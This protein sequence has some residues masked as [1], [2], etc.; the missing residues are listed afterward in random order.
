MRS[1]HLHWQRVYI[2]VHPDKCATASEGEKKVKEEKFKELYDHYEK[3]ITLL[4]DVYSMKK[5]LDAQFKEE[6]GREQALEKLKK[7]CDRFKDH[8]FDEKKSYPDCIEMAL[9]ILNINLD[10]IKK[11]DSKYIDLI[12][13]KIKEDIGSINLNLI[14]NEDA[15]LIELKN[16]EVKIRRSVTFLLRLFSNEEAQIKLLSSASG[17]AQDA[18]KIMIDTRIPQK[19]KDID[20][21]TDAKKYIQKKLDLLK[22]NSAEYLYIDYKDEMFGKYKTMLTLFP[23]LAPIGNPSFF[24]LEGQKAEAKAKA[25]AEAEAGSEYF[26]GEDLIKKLDTLIQKLSEDIKVLTKAK[27]MALKEKNDT[28]VSSKPYSGSFFQKPKEGST[29]NTSSAACSSEESSKNHPT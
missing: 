10:T 16:S 9:K 4:Q 27:K 23:T 1:S 6:W 24:I 17:L 22:E 2:Q 28:V 25:E 26:S 14:K 19:K 15:L 12:H 29:D 11:L 5:I 3:I 20:S 8:E 13:K 18:A 21:I 7:F